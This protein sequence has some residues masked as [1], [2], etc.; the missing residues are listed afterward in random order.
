M[1]ADE[2]ELRS[3]AVAEERD[4]RRVWPSGARVRVAP[5]RGGGSRSRPSAGRA[6]GYLPA[7]AVERDADRDAR[8]RRAKTLLAFAPVF[9]VVGEDTDIALAPYPLAAAR[10]AGSRRARVIAIHS[11]DHSYFAFADKKW[12]IAFVDSARVDLVPPDPRQPRSSRPEKVR[13]LADL[14][15]VDLDGEPPP[16]EEPAGGRRPE[17]PDD[18]R[19]ARPSPARARARARRGGRPS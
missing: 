12:G 19:A 9:G 16:E 14:T 10:R 3:R 7:D 6:A 1:T 18:A 5:K 15:V 8:Q 17:A 13:P 2:V 4:G 11:V